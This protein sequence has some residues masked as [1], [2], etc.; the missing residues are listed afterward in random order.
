MQNERHYFRIYLREWEF[1]VLTTD[2]QEQD[3]KNKEH[4]S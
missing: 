3:L 2:I 1:F 4:R